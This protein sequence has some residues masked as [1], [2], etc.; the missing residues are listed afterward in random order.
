MKTAPKERKFIVSVCATQQ[1]SDVSTVYIWIP[2]DRDFGY[3]PRWPLRRFQDHHANHPGDSP[4]Y[5]IIVAMFPPKIVPIFALQFYHE[6]RMYVSTQQQTL[7]RAFPSLLGLERERHMNGV[8]LYLK[9]LG[10]QNVGRFVS[11][12]PPVLGYD[13]NTNLAPKVSRP[14]ARAAVAAAA[15]TAALP[16]EVSDLGGLL[17]SVRCGLKSVR[18]LRAKGLDIDS[19][20]LC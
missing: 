15:A 2:L 11:R 10:V 4:H 3:R 12:L 19:C 17:R 18:C 14:V 8:V 1:R 7:A 20:V 9:K 16:T 5:T 6:T 13:V